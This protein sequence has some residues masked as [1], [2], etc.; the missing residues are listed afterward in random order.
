[1]KA[2]LR[3]LLAAGQ[4]R[5]PLKIGPARKVQGVATATPKLAAKLTTPEGKGV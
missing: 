4:L 3:Q 5:L 2:A 1:M